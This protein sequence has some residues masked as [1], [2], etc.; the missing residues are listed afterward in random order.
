[1]YAGEDHRLG[2]GL[3]DE[4]EERRLLGRLGL[5][6]HRQVDEADSLGIGDPARVLVVR[7]EGRD[8]GVLW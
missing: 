4:R 1:M 8:L 2:A 6:R 3:L 7:D 5:G